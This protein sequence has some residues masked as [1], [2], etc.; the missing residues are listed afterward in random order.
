M[1][2]VFKGYYCLINSYSSG[3]EFG[4]KPGALYKQLT[5]MLH[6]L[7]LNLDSVGLCASRVNNSDTLLC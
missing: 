7:V 2:V 3:Q 5:G 1:L 6:T 4:L